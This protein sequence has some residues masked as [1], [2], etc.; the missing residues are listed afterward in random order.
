M[1]IDG[2]EF[3]Q[4]LRNKVKKEIQYIKSK[5]KLTPGLTVILVG[6]STPSEIYVKN[7]EL[8]AKEVGINS[9][10]LRFKSSISEE[11]LISVIRKELLAEQ[12]QYNALWLKNGKT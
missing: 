10:V 5:S 12:Q 3:A 7:K 6:N 9:K 11:K 4:K 8:L 1:I 2:K